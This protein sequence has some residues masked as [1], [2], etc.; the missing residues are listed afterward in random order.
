MKNFSIIIP[1]HNI[2]DLLSRLIDSIP[3][4]DDIEIIVV[5]D[6]SE[7]GKKPN[8][9]L[10][11]KDIQFV[12][13]DKENS[14]GAGRARNV[15]IEKAT[16]K[17]LIFADSDDFFKNGFFDNISNYVDAEEDVIYFLSTS[18]DN[19]TL[20]PVATRTNEANQMVNKNDLNSLRFRHY[21]PWSKIVRKKMVDDY[22]LRYEEVE[23]SNDALFSVLIGIHAK[24][25]LAVNEVMYVSTVRSGSLFYTQTLHMAIKRYEV[26][27]HVNRVLLDN[28][29]YKYKP[30]L[31]TAA[32]T[33]K[34]FSKKEFYH[35]LREAYKNEGIKWFLYDC[36]NVMKSKLKHRI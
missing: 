7:E 36:W 23:V 18:V 12:F 28:G 25:V 13:L 6:N 16:G 34:P 27:L 1:H 31:V 30:N 15:G 33:I 24:K 10:F 5:D 21:V 17:W 35:Y 22:Q 20:K 2:P 11:R 9:D 8:P 14:K 29:I 26:K 4:R 19:E 3:Q 32:K